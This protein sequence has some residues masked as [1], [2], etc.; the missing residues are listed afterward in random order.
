VKFLH[1]PI[2]QR[3]RYRGEWLR[4]IDALTAAP[5]EGD[6][7]RRVIPRSAEVQLPADN[8]AVTPPAPAGTM[9]D[10]FAAFRDRIQ[11]AVNAAAPALDKADLQSLRSEIDAA[12]EALRAAVAGIRPEA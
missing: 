7:G 11:T 4:K 6:G 3:F 9:D 1:L 12:T 2:G 8:G 5:E 10:A